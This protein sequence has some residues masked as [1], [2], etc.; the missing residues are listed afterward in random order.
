M[1]ASAC[2]GTSASRWRQGCAAA[3]ARRGDERRLL[4]RR[5]R[6][7]LPRSGRPRELAAADRPRRARLHP[8]LRPDRE[9]ARPAR[10]GGR[11]VR[12]RA[13]RYARQPAEDDRPPFPPGRGGRPDRRRHHRHPPAR[14]AGRARQLRRGDRVRHRHGPLR[15]GLGRAGHGRGLAP[16]VPLLGPGVLRRRARR[17]DRAADGRAPRPRRLGAHV[18]ARQRRGLPAGAR[19]PGPVQ[20]RADN[21]RRAGADHRARGTADGVSPV[22]RPAR[23]RRSLAS[24][25]IRRRSGALCP[26]PLERE[27]LAPAVAPRAVLAPAAPPPAR[28]RRTRAR[29]R[30]D[31]P[32]TPAL[33]PARLGGP[34]AGERA[35]APALARRRAAGR[36]RGP[37]RAPRTGCRRMSA[38][39]KPS[40]AFYCVAD[41]RYFLGAVGL[42]NSL[43]VLGHDEPIRLTDCG[44]TPAQRRLLAP[45]V[46]LVDAPPD[47][48]PALLKTIGPTR[49]P[50]DVIVQLDT[51]LLATRQFG[52]L[53]AVAAAGKLIAFENKSDRWVPEWGQ[54]LD[55]GE[56]RRQHYLDFAA[57]CMHSS[58]A[59]E[60]QPLIEDRQ[61]RIDFEQTYWGRQVPD[62]PLLYA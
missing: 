1:P 35:R 26:P 10:A 43:R 48:P 56:L 45:A 20:R 42:V 53:I 61:D 8:R 21:E 30:G 34:N 31:D 13:P 15:A 62:Y 32:A 41:S 50:A 46:E 11:R 37:L 29:P 28:E 60:V 59:A 51:D 38:A 12:R 40:A 2:A 57:L 18:L 23:H 14:R 9:A 58:I 6:P 16:R 24:L 49:H 33:G 19:G 36:A 52:E 7:L 17:G 5:G 22:H 55:L 44:L 54:L 25:R 3:A 4:H 47:T 39:A 27:A